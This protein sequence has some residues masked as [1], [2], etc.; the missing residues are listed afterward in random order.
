L[1]SRDTLIFALVAV[2][3]LG[4]L[5]VFTARPG[6]VLPVDAG[7]VASSI[8]DSPQ[9]RTRCT[10]AGDGFRC[11]VPGRDIDVGADVMVNVGWDGCWHATQLRGSVRG[12]EP[13]DESGCVDLW[14]Y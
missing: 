1:R 9:V 10:G 12:V 13:A 5:L 11:L 4:V 6:V 14:D 3:L 8:G 2:G 7:N